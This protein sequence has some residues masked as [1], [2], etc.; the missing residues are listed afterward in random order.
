MIIS[1][2]LFEAYLE[3]PTK[4]WLR[5]RAEPSTGNVYA[6][7][8]S[9]QKATYC[10]NALKSLLANF[11]ESDRVNE[12]Q[13][14]RRTKDA[15]W[16]L[17]TN[18]PLRSDGL[19]TRLHALERR[20]PERRRPAQFIPYHFN[21]SSKVTKNNKLFLAFDAL[22]LT[23]IVGREVSFGKIVHGDRTDVLKV[24]LSALGREMSR[25]VTNV[26]GILAESSPPDLVLNPHCRQ[27]EF[28]ARCHSVAK[29]KDDL[30]LLS[31]MS[32]KERKNLHGKGIF[33]VTQQSY[34]FRPRRRGR[35]SQAKGEKYHH[36]L[37]ALAIR[38]NKIHA[39]DMLAPKLDGT[40]VYLDIEGLP[41][42]D[43]YYLVG[44]RVGRGVHAVQHSLWADNQD[45][46]R[47]T[48][49]EFLNIVSTVSDPRIVHFG[50]YETTFL[51]KMVA[52]YGRPG[53][54][55]PAAIAIEHGVNILSLVYAHIYFPTFSNGLKDIAGHLGFRWTGS[56]SSGLEAI[57]WR[58]RWEASKDSTVKQALIDYNR[59]D[60]EAL[61]LV[62]SRIVDLHDS[63]LTDDR[64]PHSNVILTSEIKREGHFPFRFG[65]NSFVLPELEII[66]RAAYWDYQRERV[67]VK[68]RRRRQRKAERYSSRRRLLRPNT[69]IECPRAAYCPKC[70]STFICRHGKRTKI[71]IDIRFMRHG[72]KRWITRYNIHRY[73][74]K[75][76]QNTFYPSD[77]RWTAS[78]YGSGIAAYVIYQN[79]G[80]GIPQRRVA[81]SMNDLFSLHLNPGMIWKFKSAAA[82]YYESTYA[83]LLSKLCTGQVLHV[84]ETRASLLKKECYVW[85]LT[86]MEEVAYF[87]TASREGNTIQSM[88][89]D[90]SG[91]LVSDFYAVYD[92]VECQQQKCLIHLIRDL[93]DDLLKHPFDET[94]KRLVGEFSSMVRSM[95]ETVDR[96]GLKKRFLGKYRARVQQFYKCLDRSRGPSEAAIKVMDRL[97]KNRNKLFT[98]LNFDSV[99]WN[100]NN[101]E[102]AIKAFAALRRVI[103]GKTTDKSLNDFLVLLSICETCKYKNVSFLDFLRSGS[104]DID[105]FSINRRV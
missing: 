76:C 25:H 7:W 74:C 21:F 56:P 32:E 85:V 84:D 9:L 45:G 1:A 73:R 55:S 19:E 43:F 13:I 51:K 100:N 48:W 17:A 59:E 12:P 26:S 20:P 54:G 98:F 41:D 31:G 78:R 66:N 30:S 82:K 50:A 72:V 53:E 22:V 3:C 58:H 60:C 36:S 94:L 71:E 65:S 80:L 86:S 42:R 103:D 75:S 69:I 81:F 63:V 39:V 102:H 97:K 6:E 46:E 101:A 5:S 105:E 14:S 28:Q 95:V 23:K 89:Q 91:V 57:V 33:T 62:A 68:V 24:N 35:H 44:L 96:H 70:Q 49:K 92:A 79:I 11:P 64:S 34:T 40:P 37:R 93:N 15:S 99:P 2:S 4:C 67:Y 104:T 90:F 61:E 88:L 10:E 18:V 38:E 29:Q 52:R 47:D 77:R 83:G 27:C 16:R 87:H 8:S